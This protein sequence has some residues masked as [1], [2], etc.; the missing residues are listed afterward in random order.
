MNYNIGE[1]VKYGE[2]KNDAGNKVGGLYTAFYF[3]MNSSAASI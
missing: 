2:R 3:F 1:I